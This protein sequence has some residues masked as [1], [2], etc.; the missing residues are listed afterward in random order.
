MRKHVLTILCLLALLGGGLA[1]AAEPAAAWAPV[2]DGMLTRWAA[3]VA[4]DKALPEYPRPQMVR[5][6]WQNLN[7]LWDYAILPVR[8]TQ[9]PAAFQ[10][11]I[12]V[13]F[14]VQSTLSG[15]K[16]TITPE[17]RLW[18][19]RTFSIPAAWG[20]KR[21]LL[22]FGAVDWQC[23]VWVNG[24]RIGEHSGGYDS[25]SYDITSALNPGVEQEMLI[26]VTDPNDTAPI[27]RGKQVLKPG[28]I[29][30]TAVS[31]IW[32]TAWLE[33]VP[34]ASIASLKITPNLNAKSVSVCV[35]GLETAAADEVEIAVLDGG[36]TVAS[37][38][39][40]VDKEITIAIPDPK[41]WAPG[42]PFLYDLSVSLKRSGA[43]ADAVTS[44]F[45]MR[46]I[47]LR[48]DEKGINLLFLNGKALFQHGPLDQ[49]WWPDGLYTAPTDEALKFDIEETLKMGF[50]MARK[51]VKVEPERWYYWADK[52]GL[53]VWQDMPS[54]DKGIRNNQP[55]LQRTPESAQIYEREYKALIETH[56]NHPSI[57][58]WVPFNEGWGQ[59]DTP[60]IV[61]MT[62]ELDPTR[63]VD[64]ASGWTDRGVGDVYDMHAYPGP[65]MFDVEPARASVLGEFGGLGLPVE[66]HLWVIG[67]HWGYR[68]MKDVKDLAEHY[69][70]LISALK[71]YAARGL[72]AAVY[73]QTT[74]CE[75]EVNGLL[76]Y[77]RSVN[78]IGAEALAAINRA[79]YEVKSDPTAPKPTPPPMPEPPARPKKAKAKKK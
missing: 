27:P 75:G 68:D 70:S 67:R 3:E 78:K 32:Q 8:E 23:A 61:K 5:Q 10:G 22:H 13:P 55:D 41:P 62:K 73:T 64:C 60:R 28:G 51:H 48:K 77:D 17:D 44:Y 2:K 7:G 33:P 38:K 59:F 14:P 49:G 9:K 6:D 45:G 24:K 16:K 29:M 11:R 30:Y 12:L 79:I 72:S 53:I 50:N 46:E 1:R 37:G 57:V 26:A 66:G 18:Y 63:L 56:Y 74:D 21:V 20:N 47:A 58:M 52:L 34:Q 35:K 69:A 40:S 76:T 25:F 15:V 31:G 39:G 65:N 54:G 71:V 19:H 4:P 36:K 42:T 43:E